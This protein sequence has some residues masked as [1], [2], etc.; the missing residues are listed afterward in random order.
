MKEITKKQFDFKLNVLPP[1]V[2]GK[3]QVITFL[4]DFDKNPIYKELNDFNDLLI[5]GEGSDIMEVI[6]NKG[7]KYYL[8]CLTLRVWDS[9]TFRYDDSYRNMNKEI[10]EKMGV[11]I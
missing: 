8:I 7:D 1:L 5:Q 3:N 10:E 9:E 11:T 6:G 4:R 2:Y